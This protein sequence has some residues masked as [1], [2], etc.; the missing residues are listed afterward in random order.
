MAA[1]P[2]SD[3]PHAP[4]WGAVAAV[5]ALA[6]LMRGGFYP[7]FF[8]SDEVTYIESAYR[9]LD[10]QWDVPQYVGA[11]RYGV[12][13]PVAFFS[14]LLG[15]HEFSAALYSLLCSLAEVALVTRLG[16]R[17]VG[18]RGALLAGLLLATLPVHVHYAGRLMA[19]APFALF[20]T[21]SFLLLAE[22]EARQSARLWFAAGCAAGATF[23]IKPAAVI[24]IGVLAA[25]PLL[26]QRIDWRWGWGVAG[27]AAVVLANNLFFLALTGR[28]WFMLETMGA[29]RSSGYLAAELG[30]GAL[31]NQPGFYLEYLFGKAYHTWLLGPLASAGALWAWHQ[32]ARWPS[33]R[34]Q[35]LAFVA[36]WGGGLLLLLSG[37]VVSVRPLTLIPKQVNYMLMFVAPLCLLAGWWLS[38]LRTQTVTAALLLWLLPAVLL[39]GMLQASTLVFTA[40]SKATVAYMRAHP[41]GVAHLGS[42][43]Y[44]AAQFEQ[45]V[46]PGPRRLQFKTISEA[47]V[48]ATGPEAQAE[49]YAVVDLQTILWG[50]D[51]PFRQIEQ[52]PACWQR[53]Q[54]LE[55]EVRGAGPALT[56]GLA[57]LMRAASLPAGLVQRATALAAPLKAFVYR[58]PA[59]ACP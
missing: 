35:G 58:V 54:A 27:F 39:A 6:A 3:G 30:S 31:H 5:V 52:T 57:N 40:N 4:G 53:V 41:D 50:A 14:A 13:L 15:R 28:F 21:A 49:R 9:L 8:G 56:R 48:P 59:Q 18:V 34:R 12:N 45:V 55:P 37:L 44:R 51:E 36:F 2:R 43:A 11:N 22:A 19:D 17:L 42:N 10:G 25:Y 20:A 24:Y 33:D 32:R 1:L 38:T 46:R 16:A 7:G 47:L 26:A 29:R 23:W